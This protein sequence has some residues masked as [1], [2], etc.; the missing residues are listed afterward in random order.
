MSF[1]VYPVHQVNAFLVVHG[2]AGGID[3]ILQLGNAAAALLHDGVITGSYRIQ[4]PL[5]EILSV[6]ILPKLFT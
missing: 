3:D 2:H 1:P 4:L 6:S 5:A